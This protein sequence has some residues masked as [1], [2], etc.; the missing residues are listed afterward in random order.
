MTCLRV[1]L[2]GGGVAIV[3][4]GHRRVASCEHCGK[5]HAFLCDWK[6]GADRTCDKKLCGDHAQEAAPGKHLCPDHQAAYKAWLARRAARSTPEE[7]S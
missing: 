1:P 7:R 5:P 3:C 6:V 4:G 2:E